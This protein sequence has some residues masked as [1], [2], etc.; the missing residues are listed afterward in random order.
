MIIIYKQGRLEFLP[1]QVLSH[2]SNSSLEVFNF[3]HGYFFAS[4]GGF[5]WFFKNKFL[6]QV[7]DKNLSPS[8]HMSLIWSGYPK[9]FHKTLTSHKSLI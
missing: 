4:I 2:D 8:S 9:Q 1:N 3:S 6:Q 7:L 5:S